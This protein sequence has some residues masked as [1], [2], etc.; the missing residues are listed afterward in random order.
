MQDKNGTSKNSRITLL[1]H[2]AAYPLTVEGEE[3]R[4]AEQPPDTL[5]C[6]RFPFRLPGS[7]RFTM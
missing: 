2:D 6:D 1:N 4:D 5:R 7:Q 3:R